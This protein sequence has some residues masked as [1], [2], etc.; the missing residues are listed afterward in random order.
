MKLPLFRLKNI[1]Y[2]NICNQQWFLAT[3]M[4]R[5]GLKHGRVS[6]D[7]IICPSL[8]TLLIFIFICWLRT[9]K[10]IQEIRWISHYDIDSDVV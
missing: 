10:Q 1:F 5:N 7:L 3:I 2:F 4:G 9:N 8:D 6:F